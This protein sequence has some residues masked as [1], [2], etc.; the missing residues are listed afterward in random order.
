MKN[1]IYIPFYFITTLVKHKQEQF[2]KGS[3]EK[4]KEP[5]QAL[6]L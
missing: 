4:Q 2:A 1:G 6:L 3:I 5:I